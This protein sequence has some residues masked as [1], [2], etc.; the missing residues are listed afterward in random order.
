MKDQ[1]SLY[2]LKPNLNLYV[3]LNFQNQRMK[4]SQIKPTKK[5]KANLLS[6]NLIKQKIRDMDLHFL[7]RI[8][9]QPKPKIQEAHK[10][11]ELFLGGITLTNPN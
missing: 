1:S 11:V 2:Q 10:L 5:L 3:S 9:L 6:F 4:T 7:F 8:L